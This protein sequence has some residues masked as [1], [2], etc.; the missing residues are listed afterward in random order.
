MNRHWRRRLERGEGMT[1]CTW[2]EFVDVQCRT[3]PQ[4]RF[5]GKMTVARPGEYVCTL[6]DTHPY[7]LLPLP[8][9]HSTSFHP[10]SPPPLYL[11]VL[12]RPP[13]CFTARKE[14]YAAD[15]TRIQ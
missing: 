10:P 7:P 12:S 6:I 1:P 14:G 3:H 4:N 8:P 9:P 11:F 5:A 15:A 2:D 13:M